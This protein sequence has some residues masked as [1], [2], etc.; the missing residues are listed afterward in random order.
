MVDMYRLVV[1]H[2]VA[3]G[4]RRR[5]ESVELGRRIGAMRSQ[6]IQ[7]RDLF[8]GQVIEAAKGLLEELANQ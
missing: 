8:G 7:E 3:P 2:P 5:E 1:E 6:L 4:H